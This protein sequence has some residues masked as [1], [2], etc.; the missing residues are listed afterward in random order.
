KNNSPRW[1]GTIFKWL[2]QSDKLQIGKNFRC[3]TFPDINLTQNG[4]IKIGDDVLLRRKVELRAHQEASISIGNKVRIDRGVRILGANK[5]KIVL[6]SGVRIGLY[7]VLNGGDSIA[8]GKNTLISGF[9]YLQTSMHRFATKEK[10]QDQ[11]FDHAPV[12]LADDVWLGAHVVVM[13][14]VSIENGSIVGSNAVVTQS[15]AAYKV[16]GGVPAKELK[17]R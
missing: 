15:V 10:I 11:G 3:D 8:I 17:D 12:R 4:K 16:V 13:P 1:K 2:F 9:V 7:S 6:N 5:A 14:G